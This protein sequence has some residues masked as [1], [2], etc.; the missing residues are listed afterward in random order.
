MEMKPSEI[1][2]SYKNASSKTSQIVILAELNACTRDE[3]IEILEQMGESV[4]KRKYTRKKEPENTEPERKK[5]W[6]EP[7][8]EK[9]PIPELISNVLLE[10]MDELDQK[11]MNCKREKK[12]YEHQYLEIAGYLGIRKEA[13]NAV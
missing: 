6:E 11:I 2:A 13:P 12:Q 10:K 1:L 9:V 5:E 7:K 4:P 8:L 3:I